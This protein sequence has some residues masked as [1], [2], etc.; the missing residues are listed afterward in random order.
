M[1]GNKVKLYPVT[2]TSVKRIAIRFLMELLE[3]RLSL[4]VTCDALGLA[5]PV[6]AAIRSKIRGLVRWQLQFEQPN[7]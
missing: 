7:C 3:P 4:F 1:A 6:L 2:T 5:L